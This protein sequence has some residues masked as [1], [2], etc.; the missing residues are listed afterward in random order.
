MKCLRAV[1]KKDINTEN[2]IYIIVGEN[3]SKQ[4]QGATTLHRL[5]ARG[6]RAREGG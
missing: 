5:S 1:W 3:A 4:R 2:R 6:A